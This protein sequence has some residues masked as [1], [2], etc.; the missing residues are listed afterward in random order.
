MKRDEKMMLEVSCWAGLNQRTLRLLIRISA[1]LSGLRSRAE[2]PPEQASKESGVPADPLNAAD[3]SGWCNAMAIK[4]LSSQPNGMGGCAVF[5][6]LD[7]DEQSKV[8]Q[9][10]AHAESAVDGQAEIWCCMA[11]LSSL[12][13]LA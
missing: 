1:A 6:V 2:Q 8:K 3:P 11:L 9:S 13:T 4:L 5:S 12:S 7:K 10:K